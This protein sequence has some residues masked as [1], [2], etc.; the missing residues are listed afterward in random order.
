MRITKV[1]PIVVHAQDTIKGMADEGNV[2]GY[3]GYSVLVQI[4]TDDGT[5][6]W[7]ECSPGGDLGVAAKAVKLIIQ[8]ALAPKIMGENPIEYRRIWDQLYVAME[9]YGRRGLGIFALSGI[10]TALL[11]ITGKARGAPICELFGAR[12]RK[13]IPLYASL[14]F[15]MDDPQKTAQKGLDYVKRGYKGVKFGWG[16]IPSKA[17]GKDPEKDEQIVSIIRETIGTEPLLMIDVG[18]YVDWS[19]TKAIQMARRLAKYD[20]FWLEEPLPRDDLDAYATLAAS[21]DMTIAAGE[22]YQTV[23]DFRD[24]IDRKAVDLIQ[25]DVA[26]VGGLSE[27][28]RIVELADARKVPWVPHNWSTSVNTAASLQLVASSPNASLLE[29]KEEPNPLVHGLSKQEFEVTEGEM[30][31]PRRPGLGFDIELANVEKFEVCK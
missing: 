28:R 9:P 18:R 7:G 19:V 29:F 30:T 25:P 31:I 16:L 22:G 6:G 14:L 13:S 11:D 2:G 1:H 27:A 3:A 8:K 20:I 21:V 10:D 5:E 24:I 12:Y 4:E 26:K 15:D 23:F 17:F